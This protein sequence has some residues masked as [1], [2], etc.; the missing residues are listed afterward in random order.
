VADRVVFLRPDAERI[1]RVVRAVENGDRNQQPLTFRKIFE[2]NPKAI[3]IGTVDAAWSKGDSQVVTFYD[4]TS[5]PNTVSAVNLLCDVTPASGATATIVVIG[6]HR[7]TWYYVNHECNTATCSL[8]LGSIDLTT[9][10]GFA[11]GEEQ[12]LGKSDGDC[13]KW[14]SITTCATATA[15]P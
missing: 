1:A 4:V 8:T 3:A 6:K 13:L 15:S 14:F 11:E 7:G 12:L 2:R 5:T 10:D 9:L